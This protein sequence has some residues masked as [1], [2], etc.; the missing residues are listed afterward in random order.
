MGKITA[1][2]N[3]RTETFATLA[4][5]KAAVAAQQEARKAARAAWEAGREAAAR[6]GRHQVV[7]PLTGEVERFH[8][9][10][11]AGERARALQAQKAAAAAKKKGG[12]K[13]KA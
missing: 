6:E 10:R 1:V 8:C 12:R 5:A 13:K 7:N 9:P 4:A 2:I 11:R 3:G